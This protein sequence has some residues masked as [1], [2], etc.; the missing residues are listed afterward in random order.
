MSI[1]DSLGNTL[2]KTALVIR[3]TEI[4]EFRNCRRKWWF[5]SHNGLNLEPKLRNKKLSEGIC[6]HAGLES[7]YRNDGDFATGFDAAFDRETDLMQMVIG[8]G[9]FDEEIQRD[10]Q[11][12][13]N[14]AIALAELYEQW[15]TTEAYPSDS[16]LQVIDVEKR[17]LVPIRNPGTNYKTGFWIATKL[18]AIVQ[19]KTNPNLFYGMEHKYQSK[20]TRV[21]N[22]Q[23]LPLDIQ[24]GVQQYVLQQYLNHTYGPDCIAAG[25]LYNLTRKQMPGPKVTAPLFGRHLINRS[26]K[27]LKILIESVWRDGQQM[28][29]AKRLKHERVYN[30]Q[31]T[32]I[33]TWGCAFRDVCESMNRDEDVELTLFTEFQLREHTIWQLLEEEMKGE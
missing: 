19:D 12:R 20:S 13:Y 31:Q 3:A 24:T 33:C 16:D 14:R 22:P 11:E 9:L 25:T 17:L 6:W 15:A 26:P 1:K 8:D 32:G 29:R 28:R 21:D 5:S 10:L 30:P 7:Y 23:H 27:E 18:D 4:S 2:P